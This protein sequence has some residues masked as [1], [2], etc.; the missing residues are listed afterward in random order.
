LRGPTRK[1]R[2]A[3]REV[4]KR[5][6]AI[7]LIVDKVTEKTALM[8]DNLFSLQDMWLKIESTIEVI[9]RHMKSNVENQVM[10][11]AP[12]PIRKFYF[13]NLYR[14]IAAEAET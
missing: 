3:G 6:D 4:S 14:S 9:S 13:D 5:V 11:N 7:N 8:Q 1:D 12:S 2:P 10:V